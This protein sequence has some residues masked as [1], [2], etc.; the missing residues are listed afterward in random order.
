VRPC[1]GCSHPTICAVHGC[2]AEA[3][4]GQ[5]PVSD[6]RHLIAGEPNPEL[7]PNLHAVLAGCVAGP[8]SDWPGVRAELRK[9][10]AALDKV[11]SERGG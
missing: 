9:L 7:Y 2:S 11:H 5:R 4:R 6:E 3:I 8:S 1:A 10:C